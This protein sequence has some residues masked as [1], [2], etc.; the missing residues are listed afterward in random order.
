MSQACTDPA[1][2]GWPARRYASR[3]SKKSASCRSSTIDPVWST[4]RTSV[5]LA[6][7]SRPAD[8]PDVLGGVIEAGESFRIDDVAGLVIQHRWLVAVE[9]DVAGL[10]ARRKSNAPQT[11]EEVRLGFVTGPRRSLI[12]D[13]T[14]WSDPRKVVTGGGNPALL[15]SATVKCCEPV[16]DTRRTTCH[17]EQCPDVDGQ[18]GSVRKQGSRPQ[19][20]SRWSTGEGA[21]SWTAARSRMA[22]VYAASQG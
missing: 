1:G 11:H 5:I 2:R 18:F 7:L 14:S 10:I 16:E 20:Q 6:S 19:A 12:S 21:R 17:M 15:P 13:A 9:E 4:I 8:T 22:R 3:M